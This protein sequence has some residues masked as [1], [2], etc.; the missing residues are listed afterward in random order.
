M[1][2]LYI[3][4]IE[5]FHQILTAFLTYTPLLIS[6]AK[7]ACQELVRYSLTFK[8]CTR[9]KSMSRVGQGLWLSE[10]DTYEPTVHTHRWAQKQ[11]LK[12]LR[13][14]ESLTNP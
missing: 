1:V 6:L 2:Y 5:D 10:S 4:K 9:K 13:A 11:L 8:D 12:F 7:R 14:D 3:V